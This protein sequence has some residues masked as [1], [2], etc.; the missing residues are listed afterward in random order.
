MCYV[1]PTQSH[2]PPL[3]LTID[4]VLA[5]KQAADKCTVAAE[6]NCERKDGMSCRLPPQ[7]HLL[8]V[9]FKKDN[10]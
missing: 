9:S 1:I 5:S 4:T 10:A 8:E 2:L 6:T 7:S 3:S